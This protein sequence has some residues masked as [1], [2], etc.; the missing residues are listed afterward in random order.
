MAR[1]TTV[2]PHR[3]FLE[4]LEHLTLRFFLRTRGSHT[5]K[6]KTVITEKAVESRTAAVTP[7]DR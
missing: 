1:S 7:L 6:A 2:A 5:S 3:E 4:F